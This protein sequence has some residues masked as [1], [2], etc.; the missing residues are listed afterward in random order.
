[1]IIELEKLQNDQLQEWEIARTKINAIEQCEQ[2]LK[3]MS[4]LPKKESKT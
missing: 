3:H 4:K 1:M 2:L